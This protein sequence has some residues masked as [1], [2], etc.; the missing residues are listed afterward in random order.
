MSSRLL[1]R[2]CHV[3]TTSHAATPA[4]AAIARR[5]RASGGMRSTVAVSRSRIRRGYRPRSALPVA[6]EL[7]HLEHRD[8][9]EVAH[10]AGQPAIQ[11]S[12]AVAS[13]PFE[14]PGKTR[15]LGAVDRTHVRE[16]ARAANAR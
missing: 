10:D 2:L 8:R 5:A 7:G 4:K 13:E 12:G 16:L 3:V 15:V 9:V 1:D 6:G 14:P 11:R